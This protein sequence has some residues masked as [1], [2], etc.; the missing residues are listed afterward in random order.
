MGG[1]GGGG[2]GES[3][4]NCAHFFFHDFH[5]FPLTHVINNL[6]SFTLDFLYF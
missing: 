2:G 3:V 5:G 6:E 1:G 4:M